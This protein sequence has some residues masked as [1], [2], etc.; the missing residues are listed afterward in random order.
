MISSSKLTVKDVDVIVVAKKSV[1]VLML[2]ICVALI[3]VKLSDPSLLFSQLGFGS[4]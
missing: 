1:F 3:C 4:M 2:I